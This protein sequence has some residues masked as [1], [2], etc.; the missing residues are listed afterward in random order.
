ML[1]GL[2]H[3]FAIIHPLKRAYPFICTNLNHLYDARAKYGWTVPV[4]V[5]IKILKVVYIL[6]MY[7]RKRPFITWTP[8]P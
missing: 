5:R 1:C 3:Y 2:F 6:F 8:P 7:I 4:V